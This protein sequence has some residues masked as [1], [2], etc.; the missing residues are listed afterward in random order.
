MIELYTILMLWITLLIIMTL[1]RSIYNN[2]PYWKILIFLSVM[3]ICIVIMYC[4]L[5][6]T[7]TETFLDQ[8]ELYEQSEQ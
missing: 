3:L 8:I 7:D 4:Q 1:V 5:I 2:K 6:T